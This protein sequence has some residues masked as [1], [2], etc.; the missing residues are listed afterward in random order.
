[1]PFILPSSDHGK[2]TLERQGSLIRNISDIEH[3]MIEPTPEKFCVFG[4]FEDKWTPV[5]PFMA[6][7]KTYYSKST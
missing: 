7:F 5:Y 3:S 4:N 1:M 6:Y 2:E